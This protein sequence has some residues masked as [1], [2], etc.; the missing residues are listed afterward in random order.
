[1]PTMVLALG[2]PGSPGLTMVERYEAMVGLSWHRNTPRLRNDSEK[3]SGGMQDCF[4]PHHFLLLHDKEYSVY[5]SGY[6][7]NGTN[8]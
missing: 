4:S 5:D 8:I 1:M 3:S 6:I 7:H 2:E